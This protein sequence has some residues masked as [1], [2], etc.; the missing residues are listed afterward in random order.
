MSDN[1]RFAQLQPYSLAGA[2]ALIGDTTITLKTMTD[3]DG[4]AL[5]MSGTFGTIGFGTLDPGNGVYEEQIS[6]TGLTNNA[7][8]TTTL[9]GVKNVT[10]VYPYTGT[11]GLLKTHAGSTPFVISNTS[12]FYNEFPSKDDDETIAGLWTFTQNPQSTP[13]PVANADLVNKLYADT[14]GGTA[15]NYD[16]N[17][18]AG[19]AGEN[20]TA[21]QAVYL[22]SSDGKW[23]KTDATTSSK[24]N[25]VILGINQTTVSSGAANT[26]CI[27]GVDKTQTGLSAGSIYYLSDT[28]GAIS[29]S[30]GTISVVIGECNT[31]TSQLVLS[32][33]FT[34]VPTALEKAQ[35]PT[36][37]QKNALVGNDITIAVGT[38][39]KYV[40]QTGF[41]NGA[42][43]YASS[44]G[45]A[46]AYVLTLSPVP[47]AY[48]AGQRFSF[49]ANFTNTGASTLNVNSLGAKSIFKGAGTTALIANDI[50]SG[51]VVT[52]EYDGSAFQLQ[53]GVGQS[54]VPQIPY[55]TAFE[56]SART[57]SVVVGTGARTFDTNG[58]SLTTGTTNPSSSAT[59]LIYRASGAP[60][61]FANNP[62]FTAI[63]CVGDPGTQNNPD[64]FIGVGVVTVGGTGHTYT[65]NHFGFKLVRASASTDLFATNGNGST[66]TATS[67]SAGF[68]T[69]DIIELIAQYVS[70][71]Q[72]NYY[73]RKNGGATSA[74]TTHTTNL[75][76]SATAS[77]TMQ[78]SVSNHS[79]TSNFEIDVM[80]STLSR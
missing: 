13:A 74:V 35:I 19:V 11:S 22:L 77:Q 59:T 63:I 57:T 78:Y 51:Q 16:Q 73:F 38:G 23:Y 2:G 79:T 12:G 17:I 32:Q 5:S 43:K 64:S 65:T 40:T 31:I 68:T 30:A 41:Q 9:T 76:S 10:F 66:E 50:T 44:T 29:T 34:Q 47:T 56:T 58:L 52:I 8:G 14:H 4:V 72:V 33:R 39:N 53:S 18:I 20:L 71:V 45:S 49:N 54:T 7:N 62:T 48:A 69:N 21:A 80:C 67:L 37:G 61:I 1:F 25:G 75:P 28:A 36:A 60:K 15:T 46:N 24:C 55:S 70:D 42:E 3:I 26:V 6:F 27:G